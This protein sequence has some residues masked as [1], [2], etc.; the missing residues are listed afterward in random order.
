MT[1]GTDSPGMKLWVTSPEK[2]PRSAEV[3]AEGRGNREWVA[4]R[5]HDQLQKV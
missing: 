5:L 1:M 2:E 4:E 3:L